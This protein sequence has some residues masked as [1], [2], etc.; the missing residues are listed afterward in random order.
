MEIVIDT[1]IEIISFTA[2]LS[3]PFVVGYIF[4]RKVIKANQN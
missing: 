1:I 4:E 3:I 2:V